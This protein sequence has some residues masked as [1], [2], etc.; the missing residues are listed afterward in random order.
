M[1]GA[2]DGVAFVITS[3]MVDCYN[4]YSGT[5]GSVVMDSCKDE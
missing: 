5:G 2:K 1:D 4:R 3:D